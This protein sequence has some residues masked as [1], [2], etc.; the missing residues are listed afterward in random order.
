MIRQLSE[1]GAL[2]SRGFGKHRLTQYGEWLLSATNAVPLADRDGE[3]LVETSN[4]AG[5]SSL[6][7]KS[8]KQDADT[9]VLPPLPS[10]PEHHGH[11]MF[12][13]SQMI[14]YARAAVL[15]DRQQRAQHLSGFH[16]HAYQ[17]AVPATVKESLRVVQGERDA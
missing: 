14:A 4:N 13:G 6:S 15:A 8:E 9:V 5:C 2:E 1:A 11:A 17:P 7:A 12:A 16:D 10:P 3:R